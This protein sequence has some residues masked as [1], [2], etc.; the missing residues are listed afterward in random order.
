[1]D[2]SYYRY[3][4]KRKPVGFGC[5]LAMLDSI[6]KNLMQGITVIEDEF[7][8]VNKIISKQAGIYA[9]SSGKKVCYLEPPESSSPKLAG[10]PDNAFE[11][12]GDTQNSFELHENMENSGGSQKNTVIYRT[13]QRFL[14]L[15]ELKFD[16]I[17][18]DSFSS[19]AFGMSEKEI[20]DFMEEIVRLSRQGKS[21]VLASE[22]Q[23]LTDR[24]NAYIRATVDTVIII[25]SE[26]NQ[27]KINRILYIPKMIGTKPLDRVIKITVEDEGVDIDTREFVG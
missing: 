13:D 20:V 2:I 7:G 12:P 10:F 23:M 21:F 27:G 14:P 17:V 22:S 25:R 26:I 15:E 1:V 8:A 19:Y 3:N 9:N 6:L 24:V 11:L 18:F 5:S 4:F 16:L